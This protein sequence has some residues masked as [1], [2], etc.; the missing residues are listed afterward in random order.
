MNIDT[1]KKT[2]TVSDRKS[3]NAIAFICTLV[4]FTSYV[5]RIN[6]GAVVSE[7]VR[8]EGIG[9][10]AASLAVTGL[11]ITY[12][13]G[14]LIS[15][16]LG[17]RIS[18]KYLMCAGMITASLMNFIL[19]LNT[20]P[21]CMLAVWC[22]NG[23]GQA[24]MWPPIVKLMTAYM[25]EDDYERSTVRVSWGSSFGTV[26]V[27]LLSPVFIAIGGWKSLFFF[28]A[29][30]GILG[31]VIA[32]AGISSFERRFGKIAVK[33]LKHEKTRGNMCSESK[34]ADG[35]GS[36]FAVLCAIF[37]AIFAAIVLQGVLRDGVTTWMPSYIGETF[38]L[39]TSVSILTGVV[40]PIFSIVTFSFTRAV[41][42][43]FIHN[44]LLLS[45]IL[46]AAAAAASGILSVFSGASP[47]LSV[48]CSTLVVGCMHG[49]NLLL[50][51]FVP[52]KFKSSGNISLV[53][54]V[55]NFATYVGAALSSYGFAALSDAFGWK[56]TILSWCAVS[57]LGMGICLCSAPIWKRKTEKMS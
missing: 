31:A 54:G 50:I 29:F 16:F 4:Y 21:Y 3:V 2:L 22:V 32:Y 44:E 27:Y 51:C 15:G 57:V 28:C 14:Q 1:Q 53:S 34:P 8:A 7:I 48:L 12:G 56:A 33:S 18:P 40:L 55:L 37:A 24:L 52:A 38:S 19:P 41:Y 46:F 17:D 10:E 30:L 23:F 35:S 9:K 42:G 45:G 6:Y 25:S 43:K 5:T 49:I 13:T 47:V 20:N 11:F 26:A 39:G 36:F